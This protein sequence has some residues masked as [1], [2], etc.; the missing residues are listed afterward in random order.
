MPW[1]L[2]KNNQSLLKHGNAAVK[3][4]LNIRRWDLEK[5]LKKIS[6]KKIFFKIICL[7]I[8]FYFGD[9]K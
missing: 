5:F 3:I 4:F 7:H 2:S 8:N 9:L 1:F 6:R